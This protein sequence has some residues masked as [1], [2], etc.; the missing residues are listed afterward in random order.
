MIKRRVAL[1]LLLGTAFRSRT[2]ACA[3]TDRI[4]SETQACWGKSA[5][6]IAESMTTYPYFAAFVSADQAKDM[7]DRVVRGGK[8]AGVHRRDAER[9][10]FRYCPLCL[11]ESKRRGEPLHLRRTHQLPGVVICIHH[12]EILWEWEYEKPL[13]GFVTPGSIRGK[14]V[15]S[16]PSPS[17][18]SALLQMAKISDDLMNQKVRI[19]AELF[20]SKFRAY[21]EERSRYFAGVRYQKCLTRLF[22]ET[23]GREYVDRHPTIR[24]KRRFLDARQRGIRYAVGVGSVAAVVFVAAATLV[25]RIEDAPEILA[26]SHFADIYGEVPSEAIRSRSEWWERGR[27]LPSMTCPSRFAEHGAGHFI[28]HWQPRHGLFRGRCSC[29]MYFAC[30]GDSLRVTRWSE[31]YKQEVVTLS[32]SGMSG[33][34]IASKLGMQID[35]V[36]RVLKSVRIARVRGNGKKAPPT[37]E[38]PSIVATHGRGHNV[39]HIEWF[40]DKFRGKCCCGTVIALEDNPGSGYVVRITRLG[41]L[42][43]QEVRRLAILGMSACAIAIKLKIAKPTV[44]RFLR[45]SGTRTRRQEARRRM[46]T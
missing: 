7:L 13:D 14:P 33:V 19:D 17:Q 39:D 44:L 24:S 36:R 23:F 46:T 10:R 15:L 45:I 16:E 27:S 40:E 37:V 2:T 11:S 26:D 31:D 22:E 30:D 9:Y 6:E 21:L 35:S 25:R 43:E 12:A 1:E 34:S 32:E 5:K 8:G 41:P 38:C 29:G 4:A 42:Y 28:E 20:G 18:K 3:S